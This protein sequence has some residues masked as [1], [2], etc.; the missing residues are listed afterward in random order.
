MKN[1][2]NKAK[3]REKREVFSNCL[4]CKKEFQPDPRNKKRGW[5]LFCSKSCSSTWRE[6]KKDKG[7]IRDY[8][9]N[10]LGI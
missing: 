7:D 1:L 9:L 8:R 10:Q 4:V 3:V 2:F 5:G 6:K